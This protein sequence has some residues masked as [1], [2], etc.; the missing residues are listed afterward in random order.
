MPPIAG[1]EE[2]KARNR[3]WAQNNLPKGESVNP[4]SPVPATAAVPAADE[5]EETRGWREWVEKNYK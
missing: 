3:Q 5:D 1:T 2:E 4:L